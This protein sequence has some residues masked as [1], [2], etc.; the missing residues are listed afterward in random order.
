MKNYKETDIVIDISTDDVVKD[1]VKR[2]ITVKCTCIKK[3]KE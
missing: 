2:V 1:N 3:Q